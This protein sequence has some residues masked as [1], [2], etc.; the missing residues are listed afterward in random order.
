MAIWK[1]KS[2]DRM[3]RRSG[4][5]DST[6]LALTRVREIILE[7]SIACGAL[8]R[9]IKVRLDLLSHAPYRDFV[10]GVEV[11]RLEKVGRFAAA[12][13]RR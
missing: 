2:G 9:C 7:F 11:E 8:R 13:A 1:Q 6:D 10:R 12:E 3:I 5:A 4:S